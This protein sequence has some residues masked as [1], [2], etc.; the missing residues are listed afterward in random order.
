MDINGSSNM[1]MENE[2]TP[3]TKYLIFSNSQ[4]NCN[5]LVR[6]PSAIKFPMLA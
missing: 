3:P 4:N 6:L 1:K 2:N 5:I